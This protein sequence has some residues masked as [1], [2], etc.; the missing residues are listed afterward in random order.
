[1]EKFCRQRAYCQ[2]RPDHKKQT[3]IAVRR[4]KMGEKRIQQQQQEQ[5]EKT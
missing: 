4:Q 3:S 5:E 1:V 2:A